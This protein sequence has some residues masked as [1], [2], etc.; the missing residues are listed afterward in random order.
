MSGSFSEDYDVSRF[1]GDRLDEFLV[2]L[3]LFHGL[4]T[5]IVALVTAGNNAKAAIALVNVTELPNDDGQ[6]VVHLSVLEKV[7]LV[8]IEP[9]SRRSVKDVS[10]STF[11]HRDQSPVVVHP[12]PGTQYDV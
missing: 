10:L 4:R 5:G 11:P 7:I 12:E 3:I 1:T 9:G 2:S 8:G 6:T